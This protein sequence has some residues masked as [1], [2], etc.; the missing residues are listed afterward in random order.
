[1]VKKSR[2]PASSHGPNYRTLVYVIQDIDA[3]K[4]HKAHPDYKYRDPDSRFEAL[5]LLI[6]Q[7]SLKTHSRLGSGLQAV[8][9]AQVIHR[10]RT[11]FDVHSRISRKL[12]SAG[13]REDLIFITGSEHLDS[14]WWAKAIG[15]ARAFNQANSL[16]NYGNFEV[17][18]FRAGVTAILSGS[19]ATLDPNELYDDPGSQL[20]APYTVDVEETSREPVEDSDVEDPPRKRQRQAFRAGTSI[21]TISTLTP[22]RA[23]TAVQRD[24]ELRSSTPTPASPEPGPQRT[25]SVKS[26]MLIISDG[27][28]FIDDTEPSESNCQRPSVESNIRRG[29]LEITTI[30]C[31]SVARL[32]QLIELNVQELF[33][34]D[35]ECHEPLARL[36]RLCCG[37][38]WIQTLDTF[39][40]RRFL[41]A[42]DF[43]TALLSAAVFTEILIEHNWIL[44]LCLQAEV[45]QSGE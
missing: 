26:T 27:P 15:A 29:Q 23:S 3:S 28:S 34:Y 35:A 25:T 7:Y 12:F 13:E 21:D 16:A 8:T 19:N 38:D 9:P 41:R 17:V 44:E 11:T 39:R 5:S 45:E 10:M 14:A 32:F 37:Q 31:D 36:F 42:S 4:R 2:V 40:T 24:L 20:Q 43:M 18:P 1:M 6:Q 22:D 33:T 30:S